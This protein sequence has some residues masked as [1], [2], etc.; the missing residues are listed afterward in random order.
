MTRTVF[1]YQLQ[2]RWIISCG[3]SNGSSWYSSVKCFHEL[4]IWWQILT[5]WIFSWEIWS[6]VFSAISSC[7]LVRVWLLPCCLWGRQDHLLRPDIWRTVCISFNASFSLYSLDCH[8]LVHYNYVM[9]TIITCLKEN[10]D[11]LWKSI[12]KTKQMIWKLFR[13][14]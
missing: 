5:H 8:R 13:E 7:L 2:I 12:C 3:I 4:V 9:N 1:C 10:Y 11:I 14:V 6:P